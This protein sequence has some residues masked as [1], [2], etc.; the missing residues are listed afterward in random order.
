VAGE[1]LPRAPHG[2]KHD[3][4][5]IDLM[6]AHVP[7]GKVE[8]AYHR[9]AY[10]RR[11]EP[12][13]TRADLLTHGLPSLDLVLDLLAKEF[14]GQSRGKRLSQVATNFRFPEVEDQLQVDADHA[15]HSKF[16]LRSNG[17]AQT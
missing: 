11:R 15:Y 12:A 17:P 2:K 8:G 10:L 14:M 13:T 9:A 1:L 6:L 5:V 7:T 4:K 3:R 16:F